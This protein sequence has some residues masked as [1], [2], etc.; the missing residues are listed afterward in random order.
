MRARDLMTTGLVT[1]PPEAPLESVAQILSDR[2]IS[3]AP[4]VDGAGTLLG[5]VTEGDLIRRLA[6]K[7][8]APKSWVLGLFASAAEQAARFAR[9]H[10]SRAR[11]V[12]TTDIASVTEDTSV[13]H[14]AHIIEDKKIR[15]VPVLRDG[16]LVG[17]VSRS[18][19]IRALLAAPGSIA[20]DAP[21]E[22]IRRD[23]AIAMRD[24]PWVD[25]YLIFP[26]VKDGQVTF[27]GFCRSGT[28]KQGLR[29]LAERVPGVKGVV[30]ETQDPPAFVMGVT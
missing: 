20:A 16:K 3:G 18:D 27:H 14:V 23:L 5:M 6:A 4:V 21:D 15:R 30:F 9:T 2:G 28:V 19:L 26:D 25:T 29:V 11:D 12:M 17:V 10:G 1:I 24:E 7:E 8:D 13:E 22:R